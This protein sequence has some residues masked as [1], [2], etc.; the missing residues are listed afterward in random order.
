MTPT[1][2]RGEDL[3][4][5]EIVLTEIAIEEDP[6]AG[7]E[8]V[9]KEVGGEVETEIKG[10]VKRTGDG[11]GREQEAEVETE[12]GQEMKGGDLKTVQAAKTVELRGTESQ[13]QQKKEELIRKIFQVHLFRLWR[14][15]MKRVLMRT[16][17]SRR[18]EIM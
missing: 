2:M 9:E 11:E 4:E 15:K 5:T 3:V 12:E 16:E 17:E 10:V 13:P 7:T 18:I 8:E 6:E 14:T 1:E